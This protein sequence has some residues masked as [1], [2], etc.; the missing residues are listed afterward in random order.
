MRKADWK[1]CPFILKIEDNENNILKVFVSLPVVGEIGDCIE[2][3][4]NQD[5]NEL[6]TKSKPVY[7]SD[8]EIYEIIFDKY[9]MYQKQVKIGDF[10]EFSL[11]DNSNKKIQTVVTTLHYV[12]GR[13]DK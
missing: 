6:L 1:Y 2:N 11:I 5:L 10:I 4:G 9:I 3:T 12:V 8:N 7:S 13:T